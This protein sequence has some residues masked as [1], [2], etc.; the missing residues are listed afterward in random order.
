MRSLNAHLTEPGGHGQLPFHPD[1]PVC[2]AGRLAGPL[3]V[4]P[5]VSQ[6]TQASLIAA[7]LA[8]SAGGPAAAI[9]AGAPPG[10]EGTAAP[11][12][13]DGLGQQDPGFDPGGEV[14]LPNEIPPPPPAAGGD[15]DTGAGPVEGEP[16]EQLGA[17]TGGV[18]RP[19]PAPP[20]GAGAA[21]PPPAA[22]PTAPAPG[23]PSPRAPAPPSG[24]EVVADPDKPADE[25]EK[26]PPRHSS[27]TPAADPPQTS[28]AAPPAPA[29]AAA[30]PATVAASAAAPATSSGGA[31]G[32]ATP[33][34]PEGAHSYVVRSGD[35]LWSI[36][37]R[38]LAPGAS[39][40]QIAREVHRLWQLN[41]DRIGTGSPN[42]IIA[43]QTLQLR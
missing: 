15:D 30:P 10:D 28:A 5:I 3:P 18:T 29:A 27:E 38:L 42:L 12:G 2:R 21:Q 36:A 16:Q 23:A 6:R 31:A 7:V 37:K 33:G 8:V 39:T 14:S 43:G 22:A 41:G 25:R 26:K 4:E 32:S 40:A 11:Q 17:P 20:G 13:G 34:I 19:Q 24:D 35:S 9:A 1:C